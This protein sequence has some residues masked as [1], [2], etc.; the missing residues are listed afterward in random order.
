MGSK[1]VYSSGSGD[2]RKPEPENLRATV[3]PSGIKNDGI[4]R[5]RREKAGRGGKTAT[6]V[7]GLP[8]SSEKLDA[9]GSRLKR[10]CGTGGSVK[11]GLII[12]QGDRM[13]DVLRLLAAEGFAAKKA[14]G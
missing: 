14:G 6:V 4:V 12:I 10:A 1:P 2:L 8:L 9:L 5:V 13:E 7:Y 11:D 3:P